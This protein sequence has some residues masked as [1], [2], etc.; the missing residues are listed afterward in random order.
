MPGGLCAALVCTV[1]VARP[2]AAYCFCCDLRLD[3]SQTKPIPQST[4]WL[5]AAGAVAI[6]MVWLLGLSAAV[7]A[8]SKRMQ[9]LVATGASFAVELR[10]PAIAAATEAEVEQFARHYGPVV[11]V[12]RSTT[13]GVALSTAAKVWPGRLIYIIYS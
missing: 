3:T 8:A 9:T 1:T 6:Y 13:V 4:L 2:C 11:Q 7:A 5:W 12:I 10:G